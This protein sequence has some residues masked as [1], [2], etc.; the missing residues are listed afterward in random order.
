M[1]DKILCY[2]TPEAD[3]TVKTLVDCGMDSDLALSFLEQLW[4]ESSIYDIPA[5]EGNVS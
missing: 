3:A 4:P 2:L 5:R 1:N